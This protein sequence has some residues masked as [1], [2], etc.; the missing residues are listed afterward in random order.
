M[1]GL[2]QRALGDGIQGFVDGVPGGMEFL[3][4]QAIG[5]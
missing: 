5:W 2:P 3:I 4:G 1:D